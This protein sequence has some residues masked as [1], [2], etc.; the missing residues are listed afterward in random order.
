MEARYATSDDLATCQAV[1]QKLYDLSIAHRRV[2]HNDFLVLND[3]SALIKDFF[4]SYKTDDGTILDEE[5][6][7]VENALSKPLLE[8]INPPLSEDLQTIIREMIEC[9]DGLHPMVL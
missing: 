7:Q 8:E 1:L 5:M 2:L 4:K 6:A 3:R 9:D